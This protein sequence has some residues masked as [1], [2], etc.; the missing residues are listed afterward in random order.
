MAEYIKRASAAEF[1]EKS[2]QVMWHKDDVAAALS[3]K[4]IP[5][6]DVVEVVRCRECYHK[7]EFQGR[8]MC[9]RSARKHGDEWHGLTATLAD[10]YCYSGERM[11]TNEH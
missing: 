10:C 11:K 1:F 8:M 7:V 6:A 2:N 3:G 9:G 5:T 4:S